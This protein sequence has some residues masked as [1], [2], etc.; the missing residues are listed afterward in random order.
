M[1]FILECEN[2]S[3]RFDGLVALTDVSVHVREGDILGVIGPNGAGKT[4]LFNVITG[5]VRPTCGEIYLKGHA[6]TGLPP[7]RICRAG[8]ARTYQPVRPFGLLT[9]LENVMVGVSFGRDERLSRNDCVDRASEVL[10]F[11]GLRSKAD[12]IA[13]NL[14]LV[15]KKRLEIARGLATAPKVL[16]LDEVI[17]GLT[18]VE[19][20]EIMETVREIRR[21]GIT[22]IVIEHVMKVV[23]NLCSTMVVLHHGAVIAEGP[24]EAVMNNHRVKEAYL[25]HS[26][27]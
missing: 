25:G 18:P 16:L 5:T 15:E 2:L 7:E 11:V 12:R 1:T 8:I 19:A 4:T 17:S 14:T 22:V 27:G 9:A 23:T 3:V 26:S 20:E 21:R 6:I 24:P 13:Q 10:D